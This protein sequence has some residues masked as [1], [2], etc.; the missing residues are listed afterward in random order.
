MRRFDSEFQLERYPWI[1][2]GQQQAGILVDLVEAFD[3]YP[4]LREKVS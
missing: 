4:A 2:Q 3:L 1:R